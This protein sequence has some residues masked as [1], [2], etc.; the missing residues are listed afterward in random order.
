MRRVISHGRYLSVLAGLFLIL[1]VGL[2]IRPWYRSDWATENALVV[3]LVIALAVFRRGLFFSRLSY[4]LIF[5]FLC[6]HQVG[7][8]YTYAEVPYNA[9]WKTV[10]GQTLNSLL[11]WERNNFDRVVH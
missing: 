7:A 5:L 2:A 1:W 6:L 3:L 10:T 4:T 11:G 9:W 8:H